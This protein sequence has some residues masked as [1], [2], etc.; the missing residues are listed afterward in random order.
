MRALGSVEVVL[1]SI[2][3]TRIMEL[4]VADW[5]MFMPI[6]RVISTWE[7]LAMIFCRIVIASCNSM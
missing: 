7:V 3:K 4:T 5:N 6:L 2:T 1:L